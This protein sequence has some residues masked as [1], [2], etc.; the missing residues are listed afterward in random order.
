MLLTMVLHCNDADVV[1]MRKR[2]FL[3]SGK[4]PVSLAEVRTLADVGTLNAIVYDVLK[5][6]GMADVLDW[7]LQKG[8]WVW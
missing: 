4:H 8:E 7:V 1:H 6:C 3:C 2:T 5:V